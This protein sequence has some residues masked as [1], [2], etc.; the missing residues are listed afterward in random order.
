MIAVFDIGNKSSETISSS[1]NSCLG[2]YYQ[3]HKAGGTEG[4]HHFKVFKETTQ[5]KQDNNTILIL[6]VDSIRVEGHYI[7]TLSIICKHRVGSC[8]KHIDTYTRSIYV[9]KSMKLKVAQQKTVCSLC[10]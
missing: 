10:L 1:R 2:K 8:V 4:N 9:T 7:L 5:T 6:H 3:S